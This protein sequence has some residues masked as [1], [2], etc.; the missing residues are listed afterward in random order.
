MTSPPETTNINRI[1]R[2]TVAL[3][4]LG[5]TPLI[6]HPPFILNR[7]RTRPEDA[8]IRDPFDEFRTSAHLLADDQPTL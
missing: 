3:C 1:S 5:S 2:A 7:F 4:V 8:P 6:L